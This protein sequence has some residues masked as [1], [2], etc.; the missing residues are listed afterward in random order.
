M[1]VEKLVG[2]ILSKRVESGRVD[3]CAFGRVCS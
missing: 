2:M 3:K 1:V